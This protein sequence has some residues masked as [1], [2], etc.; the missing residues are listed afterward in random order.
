MIIGI[1]F[2]FS[3]FHIKLQNS[4]K[5]SNKTRRKIKKIELIYIQITILSFIFY[6][7]GVCSLYCKLVKKVYSRSRTH[8]SVNNDKPARTYN[9][10]YNFTFKGNFEILFDTI[11]YY[12]EIF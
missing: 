10:P 6:H 3:K 12:L 9:I 1:L 7:F 8:L 5:C 4:A 2:L 11:K